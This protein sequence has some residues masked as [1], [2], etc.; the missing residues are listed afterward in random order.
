METEHRRVNVGEVSLHVAIEGHGPPVLLLHGFPEYGLSWRYQMRA[1]ADAGFQAIA[2]DLRGYHRSDRPRGVAAYDIWR[3]AD[4]AAGVLKAL[5][6]SKAH[7]V[8]H[9]W[10]GVVAYHAALR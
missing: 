8:W 2:P 10:G 5:G 4:D 3:L 9:D 6:H 1:L 7:W